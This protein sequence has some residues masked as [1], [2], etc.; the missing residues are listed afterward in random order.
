MS[1][2]VP[3]HS[4]LY[5]AFLHRLNPFNS[6]Y[7]KLFL[8]SLLKYIQYQATHHSSIK[9]A[10]EWTRCNRTSAAGATDEVVVGVSAN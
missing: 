8:F 6:I 10:I 9:C 4:K 3:N 1:I 5:Y 7:H 2:I